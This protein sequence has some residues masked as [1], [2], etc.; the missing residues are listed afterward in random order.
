MR[1][2]GVVA[3][4][5]WLAPALEALPRRRLSPGEREALRRDG[6][7]LVRGLLA[8]PRV[9][10]HM[11]EVLGWKKGMYYNNWWWNGVVHSVIKYSPLAELAASALDVPEVTIWNAQLE[12]RGSK[13][14]RTWPLPEK[15]WYDRSYGDPRDQ[16]V[17]EDTDAY[18]GHLHKAGHFVKPQASFFIAITDL[19]RGLEFLAGSHVANQK[20]RCRRANDHE[21]FSVCMDRLERDCNG[22]LGWDLK[23]G[24]AILF[25]GSTF[26]WTVFQE[27]PRQAI[28][29]RYVPADMMF[30]GFY[31]DPL[32]SHVNWKCGPIGG[33][34]ANPILFSE[35]RSRMKDQPWPL[36]PK[37]KDFD[38]RFLRLRELM[39]RLDTRCGLI[40][41]W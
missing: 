15:P 40:Y 30:T 39:H 27:N 4:P 13:H 9:L 3:A 37:N 2:H 28:S 11:A 32:A 34:P 12:P 29:I 21:D 1:E 31:V 36:F 19:P 23:A 20:H 41:D 24:D 22:S 25:Y 17:H 7:I 14:D 8:E 26:H 6:A 33:S 38:P 35:N 16:S 5:D 10:G 18:L